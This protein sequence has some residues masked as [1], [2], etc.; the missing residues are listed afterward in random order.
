M[1]ST[2]D[3]LRAA[4]R[5]AADT[6]APGSAPPLHLPAQPQRGQ[7]RPSP[8][9]RSGWRLAATPLAAA[10]AVLAVLAA[11]LAL[12][13][14]SPGNRHAPV[15]KNHASGPARIPEFYVAIVARSNPATGFPRQYAEVRA[16]GSGTVLATI[17]PPAPY[18]TLVTVSA[19]AD[20][21][22]FVLGVAPYKVRHDGPVNNIIQ[23]PVK[24]F[25]LKLSPTGQVD[26]LTKLP[27]PAREWPSDI[28]LSPDGSRLA[29]AVNHTRHRHPADPAIEVFT[30]SDGALRTWAWTGEAWITNNDASN[31]QLMSWTADGRTL[32]F[33]QWVGDD[34]QVRLLDTTAPGS[35]LRSSRLVLDFRHQAFTGWKFTHGKVI[36]A[37]SGY[38][39]LITLDG[40]KIIAGTDTVTKHPAT[41]DPHF[42]VFS[43]RTGAVLRE[44]RQSA[45]KAGST[46][47]SQDVLWV[48]PSGSAFIGSV[49]QPGVDRPVIGILRGNHFAALPGQWARVTGVA[50]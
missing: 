47:Q 13:H 5:A 25:L 29:V 49:L 45:P 42:T 44:L 14:G 30:L 18:R 24:F 4:V 3:R 38:N 19:A 16:T 50:W 26:R 46:G 48:S 34:E 20:D 15:A 32:A 12:A 22:T 10:A 21:R 43:A 28:A 37:L 33:E 11:S 39:A 2:E 9:R 17:R 41:S 35:D 31:R 1:N 7:L 36:D 8:A 27:I 40:T 23:S 6:V